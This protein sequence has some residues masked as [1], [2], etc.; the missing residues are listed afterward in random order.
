MLLAK[1]LFVV[2][3]VTAPALVMGLVNVTQA[4]KGNCVRNVEITTMSS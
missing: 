2:F 4:L 1:P 3:R